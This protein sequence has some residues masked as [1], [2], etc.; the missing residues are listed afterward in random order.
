MHLRSPSG[1]FFLLR[2][3]FDEDQRMRKSP[4]FFPDKYGLRSSRNEQTCAPSRRSRFFFCISTISYPIGRSGQNWKLPT[5]NWKDTR[6]QA[7]LFTVSI[8][9]SH[10]VQRLCKASEFVTFRAHWTTISD[11]VFA[12][13]CVS[14]V[15]HGL[16]F[17]VPH[18]QFA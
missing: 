7:T 9:L 18:Q 4:I 11:F 14:L 8:N 5:I 16:C 1:F 13:R 15:L 17:C 10:V 6:F 3:R 12:M 2:S